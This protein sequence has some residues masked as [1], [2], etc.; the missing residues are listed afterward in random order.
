MC[1]FRQMV[2]VI[3]ILLPNRARIGV[4]SYKDY[5]DREICTDVPIGSSPEKIEDFV[6][7]LSATGGGD[8]PEATK[9][10]L[11]RIAEMIVESER[12]PQ[13]VRRRSIVIHYT[14]APP[15]CEQSDSDNK[16]R[17]GEQERLNGKEPGYDWVHI[18]RWFARMNVPV[19]TFLT[20][21]SNG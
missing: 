5:C 13:H 4:I 16:N 14:D 11:N 17:R 9:T 12:D 3:R 6:D 2:G 8:A 7:A 1:P 18:C 20:A 21:R 19:Y 10:G 15:H